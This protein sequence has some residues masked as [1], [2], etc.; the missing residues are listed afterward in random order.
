MDASPIF[1]AGERAANFR[2]ELLP[3]MRKVLM[4]HIPVRRPAGA[5]DPE[6]A[7]VLQQ[8]RAASKGQLNASIGG[9]LLHNQLLCCPAAQPEAGG[10]SGT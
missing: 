1:G 5:L 2:Q 10:P 3:K 6:V 9:A 8:V 4:E 7:Q